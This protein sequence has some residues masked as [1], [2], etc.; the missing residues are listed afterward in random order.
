MGKHFMAVNVEE[1]VG[2]AISPQEFS[3]IRTGTVEEIV[4]QVRE[5]EQPSAASIYTASGYHT[6][7]VSV[8][9]TVQSRYV[10]NRVTYSPLVASGSQN[11]TTFSFN[12]PPYMADKPQPT[13]VSSAVKPNNQFTSY[14]SSKEFVK[15]PQLTKVT[16]G[17]AVSSIG[18]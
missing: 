4:Y 15:E 10:E 8:Q 6:Q 2:E 5:D 12:H 3:R 13:L 17:S 9:P 16:A 14:I 11:N 1:K 7:R 18:Q